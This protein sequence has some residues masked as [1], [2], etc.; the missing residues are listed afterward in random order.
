MG[1]MAAITQVAE[2]N[3]SVIAS[4]PVTIAVFSEEIFSSLT[5][6]ST[7][8]DGLLK[9]WQIRPH[10]KSQPTFSS[11]GHLANVRFLSEGEPLLDLEST[12]WILIEGEVTLNNQI[13]DHGSWGWR[14]FEANANETVICHRDSKFIC[15]DRD[16]LEALRLKTP[17][18]NYA[19]R[20]AFSSGT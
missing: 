2:R 12:W 20:M 15:F 3:A 18:L 4:T 9:R 17:Q 6:D 11:L 13:V 10:L 7:F 8:R 14:P 19:L 5:S 16:A 1:E